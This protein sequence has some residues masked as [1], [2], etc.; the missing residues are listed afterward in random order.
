MPFK[1]GFSD[2]LG[3]KITLYYDDMNFEFES[4]SVNGVSLQKSYYDNTISFILTRESVIEVHA[5]P[6]AMMSLYLS[7]ALFIEN[8]ANVEF[9]RA[10]Y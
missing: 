6:Y 5:S 8:T 9:N 7:F 10:D 3:S 4:V 2:G 1:N